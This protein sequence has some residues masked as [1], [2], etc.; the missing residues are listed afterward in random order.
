ML[1]GNSRSK[2]TNQ[3]RL[4]LVN[5]LFSP[6]AGVTWENWWHFLK[7]NG[8]SISARYWPRTLFTTGMA[9]INSMIAQLE[10]KGY[11]TAI[12]KI[13]IDK[14]VFIIGH[15]RSGT[16][17]LW[18]LLSQDPQ[19]AYPNVIQAVFPHTFLTYEKFIEKLAKKFVM[20]QRP[21]DNVAFTPES[22]LEEERAI[23]TSSFLSLQMVRHLPHMSDSFKQYLSM[24]ETDIIEREKWK[25]S[26]DNFAK[27]LLIRY[28]Q[29]STLL[30]KS[31]DN[32]AKVK[33]LLELYPDARFIHIHR[34]PYRVFQSTMKM[35]KKII[36][37]YA[38]QKP[39]FDELEDFVLWRYKTMYDA[40]LD[41][42]PEIPEGQFVEL[43]YDELERQPLTT[44]K[45]VY[46]TLS[47]LGYE[48]VKSKIKAYLKSISGYKKNIYPD[49]PTHKKKR[50]F[51]EWH[52]SFEAFGYS[53]Y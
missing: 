28:G 29:Y 32:T 22:P 14:P 39:M 16:T 33:L 40:L 38:Y 10:S 4:C 42:I 20:Q 9:A 44:L 26:L 43:A 18:N 34:N 3:A 6:L 30:F 50:I 15:N 37:L 2:L 1:Q 35:E 53:K 8:T 46:D 25:L 51:K 23:C 36:P 21:Q 12:D 49:L 17:H 45:K 24:K 7:Y 27:K 47:L 13:I 19:F 5:W 52:R 48:E 31:P 41:D 11:Q